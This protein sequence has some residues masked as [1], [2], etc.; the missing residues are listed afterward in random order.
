MSALLD[1]MGR[2]QAGAI[3]GNEARVKTLSTFMG[4]GDAHGRVEDRLKQTA[5]MLQDLT[6]IPQMIHDYIQA[7]GYRGAEAQQHGVQLWRQVVEAVATGRRGEVK[8]N[9]GGG[10]VMADYGMVGD[11]YMP[12]SFED[13]SRARSEQMRYLTAGM[14]NPSPQFAQELLL[15]AILPI[16]REMI[17]NTV[18][19][20]AFITDNI[21]GQVSKIYPKKDRY[22]AYQQGLAEE[23][24]GVAPSQILSYDQFLVTPRPW[25][26]T[27]NVDSIWIETMEFDVPANDLSDGG[28]EMQVLVD[29]AAFRGLDLAVPNVGAN[30]AAGTTINGWSMDADQSC[31]MLEV[32]RNPQVEDINVANQVLRRRGYNPDLIIIDPFELGLMMNEQAVLMAYAYGTREVQE[33]GLVGKLLGNSVAWC[34]NLYQGGNPSS[35]GFWVCDSDELARTVL[36][37]PISLY[38]KIEMRN[39][40]MMLYTRLEI[41]L[42]NCRACVKVVAANADSGFS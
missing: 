13:K 31:M 22:P 11:N 20:K 9:F 36:G 2:Q 8:A 40:F 27:V 37:W 24:A 12:A 17:P 25:K 18:W 33:T 42:R 28:R 29:Q 4:P 39:L 3:Q 41:L 38:S 5:K 32:G 16:A 7:C 21:V 35:L 14:A 26:R 34:P 10:D 30:P 1:R 19:T 6:Q 23:A 15:N